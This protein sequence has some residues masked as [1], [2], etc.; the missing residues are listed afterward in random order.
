MIKYPKIDT[1]FLRDPTT[2]FKTLLMGQYSN[3]VFEY[4]QENTWVFTEK[5][6]G[7]NI[8]VMWDGERVTFGGRTDDAQMPAKLLAK[9]QERFPADK[10]T[11]FPPQTCLYGEGFGAGIKKGGGNYHS[12]QDF[13]LFDVLI[14]DWW[15]TRT[16]VCEIGVQLDTPVVPIIGQGTLAD[17]V[18]TV[19]E[20]FHSR[21]WFNPDKR[22]LAEGI[23]A[24]PMV[25]LK[26]RAGG[27]VI[28]KLKY[29]DFA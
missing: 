7:T 28:T 18:A 17:L 6:D 8:R 24:R 10:F 29:R 21:L 9:L 16:N 11:S 1:V 25:E 27:R 13:I 4:L 2:K 3:P 15:L 22:F 5:V 26:T 23:V 12:A 20:G 14:G 19:K